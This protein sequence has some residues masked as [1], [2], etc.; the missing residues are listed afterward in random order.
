MMTLI[1]TALFQ[2]TRNAGKDSEEIALWIAYCAFHLGDFK[3]A[4]EV[5]KYFL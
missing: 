1:D 5:K 3:K 4:M 2:F